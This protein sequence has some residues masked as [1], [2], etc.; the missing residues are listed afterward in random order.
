[1]FDFI[2]TPSIEIDASSYGIDKS[3][4]IPISVNGVEHMSQSFSYE[5]LFFTPKEQNPQKIMDSSKKTVTIT[6]FANAITGTGKNKIINGHIVQCKALG[7]LYNGQ[8]PYY[9]YK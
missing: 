9:E 6:L 4:I 2:K 7:M 8:I 5:V 3:T 1:M